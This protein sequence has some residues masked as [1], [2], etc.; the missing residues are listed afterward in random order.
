MFGTSLTR[1]LLGAVVLASPVARHADN[2]ELRVVRH[3]YANGTL[4][5]ERTYL[6]VQESG[7]HRGWWPDGAPR[8][9][10]HYANGLLEGE[11]RE[12][13][14]SGALWRD[15]QYA[16][17]HESGM[18]RLYWEDGRVRASYEVRDGRRFGLMGAKG[19]VTK[20]DSAAGRS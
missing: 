13:F 17:G 5:E 10:Y 2:V 15:Q 16:S 1:L 19:C 3:W 8:F 4:A 7:V 9:E 6:G 18:Q 20:S 14:A 11:S 12:W